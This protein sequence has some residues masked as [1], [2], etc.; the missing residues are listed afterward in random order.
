[1]GFAASGFEGGFAGDYRS[2]MLYPF[3]IDELLDTK[4]LYARF[5]RENLLAADA[6]FRKPRNWSKLPADPSSR[7]DPY[8]DAM[9]VWESAGSPRS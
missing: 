4:A 6:W 1:M 9:A 2:S 5:G 8:A 3:F 7:A